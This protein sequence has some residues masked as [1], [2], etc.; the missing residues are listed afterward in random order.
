MDKSQ[1]HEPSNPAAAAAQVFADG[2]Q[3]EAE[4]EQPAPEMISIPFYRLVELLAAE[5]AL[6]MMA[7]M[8]NQ[9]QQTADEVEESQLEKIKTKLEIENILESNRSLREEY[10]DDKRFK[11]KVRKIHARLLQPD[12]VRYIG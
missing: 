1:E 4:S 2:T 10:Y 11:S 9:N 12:S 6:S 3:Q 7:I 5:K 8:Q